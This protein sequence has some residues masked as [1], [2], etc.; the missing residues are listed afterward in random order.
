MA[1]L[2][3]QYHQILRGDVRVLDVRS[4]S[5]FA[6]GAVPDAINVPILDDDERTQ[7]GITYKRLGKEAAYAKGLELVSGSKRDLR[8]EAWSQVLNQFENIAIC[9]WRG[10]L[11]S[12]VAQQ[13]LKQV[14]WEVPR[15]RGGSKALRQF[16]LAKLDDQ[17]NRRLRVLGGRTGVGKTELLQEFSAV[18]DLEELANHRGSAFGGFKTA[19]PPPV[20]FEASLAAEL[21]RT[22]SFCEVM[23]EDESRTIGRLALPTGLHHEMQNAPLLILTK[24]LEQRIDLTYKNYVRQREGQALLD[25]LAKIE[26]RLGGQR[27]QDVKRLMVQAIESDQKSTHLD[28]IEKLLVYYYDPQYD[29]QLAR[30]QHRVQFSGD[31]VAMKEYLIDTLG[32]STISNG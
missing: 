28:W 23:V 14:G 6:S 22:D 16:V 19:Q 5:E 18:I 29:Y 27:Y 1:T 20:S 32:F 9:C 4:E 11:R 7:V 15:V 25:S 31:Y 24:P 30:K 10:G 3:D 17:S 8:V 13:W 12:E 26:R 21:I 2:F